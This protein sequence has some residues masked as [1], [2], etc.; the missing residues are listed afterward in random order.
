MTQ[1]NEQRLIRLETQLAFQDDLLEQLNRQLVLQ[2]EDIRLLQDQLH[3][4]SQRFRELQRSNDAG[5]A[6]PSLTDERPPHY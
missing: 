6:Q 2:A 1:E 4:L 5:E 3:L